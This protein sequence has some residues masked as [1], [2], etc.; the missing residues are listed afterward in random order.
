MSDQ[1]RERVEQGEAEKIAE[2]VESK[3]DSP[4][5][6][7]GH[8]MEVADKVEEKWNEKVADA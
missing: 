2:R 4:D 8:R 3:D 5:D 1:E 6:F 7:E